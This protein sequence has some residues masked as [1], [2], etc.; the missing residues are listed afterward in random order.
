MNVCIFGARS[1]GK[2]AKRDPQ[3]Q[4]LP[5]T[6]GAP[7]KSGPRETPSPSE[8]DLLGKAGAIVRLASGATLDSGPGAR[9]PRAN[10]TGRMFTGDRSGDLLYA[11]LARFGFSNQ[12]TSQH[13]EDGLRLRDTYITAT[14]H[15]APPEKPTQQGG[16]E[17]LPPYLLR[18][19]ELLRNLRVVVALGGIAFSTYLSARRELGQDLPCPLP[20]FGHGHSHPIRRGHRPDRLLPPQST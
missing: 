19:L 20:R 4:R 14:I 3:V 8:L 13:R 12:S 16:K 2:V 17:L 18:E 9:R 5:A 10:R 15:C 1:M 11:T 6:G 7:G